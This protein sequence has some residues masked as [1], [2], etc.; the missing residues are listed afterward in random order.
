[1]AAEDL[2]VQASLTDRAAD[3]RQE[4]DALEKLSALIA[5]IEETGATVIDCDRTGPSETTLHAHLAVSIPVGVDDDTTEMLSPDLY[6]FEESGAVDID[7]FPDMDAAPEDVQDSEA[8]DTDVADTEPSGASDD[9]VEA[10]IEQIQ[11]DT[12][13]ADADAGDEADATDEAVDETAD[14]PD[15]VDEAADVDADESVAMDY[16]DATADDLRAAIADHVGFDYEDG[17]FT[18]PQSRQVLAALTDE[19]A[20]HYAD[21]SGSD[22]KPVFAD[23]LGVELACID[24]GAFYLTRDE[25]G[26]VHRQLASDSDVDTTTDTEADEAEEED[27]DAAVPS[28]TVSTEIDYERLAAVDADAPVDTDAFQRRVEAVVEAFRSKVRPDDY[29]YVRTGSVAEAADV[30]ADSTDQLLELFADAEGV[31]EFDVSRFGKT[32]DKT[33]WR[34]ERHDVDGAADGAADDAEA[35]FQVGDEVPEEATV[36]DEEARADG[37]TTTADALP[38]AF[39]AGVTAASVQ[40]RIDDHTHLKDFAAALGMDHGRL[41]ANLVSMGLYGHLTEGSSR[42]DS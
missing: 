9:A 23:V 12:D 21:H 13:E 38:Y 39:P 15:T 2:D 30:N 37:G 16:E 42:G 26:A 32:N 41:R 4:A 10:A 22:L 28:R 40:D 27:D 11:D 6:D 24:T 8:D 19:P 3:L 31:A 33:R 7:D 25:V 18:I 20:D 36:D 1:M 17:E 14:D 35:S 5:T 29:T 34:I